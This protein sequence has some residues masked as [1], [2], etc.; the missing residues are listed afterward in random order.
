[1]KT[2]ILLIL[3]LAVL[4]NISS[5]A[6]PRDRS[7]VDKK[8]FNTMPDGK[9]TGIIS[10]QHDRM[11]TPPLAPGFVV[12]G[13]EIGP[14]IATTLSGFYDY[15][16]NG[17][18]R[19]FIQQ[20]PTNPL[21]IHVIYTVTD[22][23]DTY[24]SPASTRRTLYAVSTDGGLTWENLGAVP[25]DVRTGFGNVILKPTG[26]AMVVL[27][28]ANTQ[29]NV[30]ISPGIGTWTSYNGPSPDRVWP[31]LNRL[32]NGNYLIVSNQNTTA[33]PDS[34]VFSVFNGTNLSAWGLVTAMYTSV[35]SNQRWASATG[36]SGYA[37]VVSNPV[38][39]VDSLN[40]EF[41]RAFV[42]NDNAGSFSGPSTIFRPYVD[43]TDT[44]TA[45]FGQDLT[46]KPGTSDWYF[47]MNAVGATFRSAKLL[48][49]RKNSLTP[50]VIA[51]SSDVPVMTNTFSH[52]TFAGIVGIDHPA[53]GWSED[54]NVLYCAYS[55]ATQDTGAR[56][57][58][59]RDIFYSYSRDNGSTWSEAIRITNTPT[60]DEGY[61]SISTWNK[62][63]GSGYELNLT[64]M[65]DPGDGPNAFNAGQ[66]LA[67]ATR[68]QQ[69]YRKITDA[70]PIGIINISGNVPGS[71]S[72]EQNYPNPFNPSTTI[73]FALPKADFVTLKVYNAIGQLVSTLANNEQVKA[74]INEV[75]FNASSLPS[76]IY[77]YTIKAGDF[78][79]TKKM[80]LI[81]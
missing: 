54:G 27:H 56:G 79:D 16:T 72:L 51:D 1:M 62:G 2:K 10:N 73:K 7:R 11:V 9:T 43:G 67:P 42:S 5:N 35:L 6:G 44:V 41:V 59:T 70:A 21:L 50:I 38:S 47:A 68:N 58:N 81:K 28:Q 25:S 32:S 45:F 74:G 30:D 46:V 12:S 71:F 69:I 52:T 31:Q 17:D 66:E 19:H 75:S 61:P 60:I 40:S 49:I 39:V 78:T 55:V 48:M 23:N 33:A 77:F 64:Y 29:L 14:E 36:T 37:I 18:H 65:K 76:G 20:S 24:P 3:F 80:M 13:V 63:N 22:T 53:L 34:L 8:S 26:E 57:W 15:M 4:I